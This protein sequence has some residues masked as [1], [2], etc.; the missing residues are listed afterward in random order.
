MGL[1]LNNRAASLPPSPP[2]PDTSTVLTGGPRSEDPS[3]EEV[4]QNIPPSATPP[5]SGQTYEYQVRRG[6]ASGDIVYDEQ[7]NP[8]I[9][10]AKN[11][12]ID[13]G[14]ELRRQ[15]QTSGD[16]V[17]RRNRPST[18]PIPTAPP[19]HRYPKREII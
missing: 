4:F 7:G 19:K 16:P 18:P 13:P 5:G 10:G 15:D 14:L 11:L 2:V 9:L 8:K 1:M 6:Q 17:L 12:K 3:Y